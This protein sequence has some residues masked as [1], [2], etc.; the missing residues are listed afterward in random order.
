MAEFTPINTQEEFDAAVAERYGDVGNLQAQVEAL[1]GERDGHA[2][3]IAGLQKEINGYKLSNLK[4][5][6]A[7]EKGIPAEMADRLTGETEKDI[8]T[9]ADTMAGLLRSVRG[10]DPTANNEQPAEGSNTRA[11]L[12]EM[13]RRMK[14]E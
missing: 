14:G 10:A 1:T 7:R 9:D 6:I 12:R 3:T 4:Q 13:L 8:R 11:G 5:Q 2:A